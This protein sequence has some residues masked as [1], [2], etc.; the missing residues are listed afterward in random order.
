MQNFKITT[1]FIIFLAFVAC[2]NENAQTLLIKK[3]KLDTEALK[4]EIKKAKKEHPEEITRLQEQLAEKET[5]TIDFKADATVEISLT[6]EKE[7]EKGRWQMSSDHKFLILEDAKGKKDTLIIK[8]LTEKKLILD[9][10]QKPDI[11][12]TE[13]ETAF[14]PA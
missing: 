6:K 11:H 12:I 3:W 1:L 10:I 4:E 5:N 7:L 8:E 14:V 2:K 13:S 9:I